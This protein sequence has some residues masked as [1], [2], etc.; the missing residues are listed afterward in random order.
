M[1]KSRT[2]R[3][4]LIIVNQTKPGAAALADTLTQKAESLG[5]R[6]ELSHIYPAPS[7]SFVD[8]QLALTIGGDGTLLNVVSQA[9]RNEVPLLAVNLGKLGFLATYSPK[10]IQK[11]LRQVLKGN[12]ASEQRTLLRCTDARGQTH[13][14]LNDVVIKSLHSQRLHHVQVF[15]QNGQVSRLTGDGVIF[16]TP[17]GSTAYNLSAG[18]P[19]M[20][21]RAEVFCMTPICPHTLSNRSVILDHDQVIEVHQQDS[22]ELSQVS[23]D[24]EVLDAAAFPLKIRVAKERLTLIYPKDYSYFNVLR[25]KL[26]WFES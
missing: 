20:H 2:I 8:K 19:I 25:A 22:H 1:E 24:G 14:V 13:L 17:T 11:Q 4:L 12:Y 26:G 7:E 15:S 9:V 3:S 16:A 6:V 23:L 21:P 5:V 18:G 10:E